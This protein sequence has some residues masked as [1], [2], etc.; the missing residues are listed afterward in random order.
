MVSEP[1]D[2]SLPY[3]WGFT[4]IEKQCL[5]RDSDHLLDRHRNSIADCNFERRT[6]RFALVAAYDTKRLDRRRDLA[7]IAFDNDPCNM[8]VAFWIG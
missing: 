3:V 6:N 8:R 4:R 5:D 2:A 7:N 1:G